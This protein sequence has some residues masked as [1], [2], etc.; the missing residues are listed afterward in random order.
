M[1]ILLRTGYLHGYTIHTHTVVPC[2]LAC[3]VTLSLYAI[4]THKEYHYTPCNA[5]VYIAVLA[6][7]YSH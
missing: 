1:H 6:S 3:I 4:L 7:T 2:M 5:I